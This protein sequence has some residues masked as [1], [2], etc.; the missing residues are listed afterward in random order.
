M[1]ERLAPLGPLPI[2]TSPLKRTR[3]TAAP[4]EQRWRF[5]ARIEPAVGEIPSPMDDPAARGPWLRAVMAS[6]WS[7]Q[8]DALQ[9]WRRGVADALVAL[10]RPTVVVTH[11]IAINAAVGIAGGDD[12]VVSFSPDNCSVTVLDVDEGALRLVRRGAEAATRV[13]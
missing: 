3:E 4:L 10:Q 5:T 11:F 12:R 8:P 6:R 13:L 1:A 9:A 7:E 2:V